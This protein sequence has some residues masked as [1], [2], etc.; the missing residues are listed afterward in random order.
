MEGKIIDFSGLS[1]LLTFGRPNERAHEECA[2][3]LLCC[4]FHVLDTHQVSVRILVFRRRLRLGTGGRLVGCERK[5]RLQRSNCCNRV[6]ALFCDCYKQYAA[7]GS[8]AR[9]FFLSLYF[10]VVFGQC[11][12]V[13][14]ESRS[15]APRVGSIF[16]GSFA[17]GNCLCF[18]PGYVDECLFRMYIHTMQSLFLP[19]SS[20]HAA[21][22]HS[23]TSSCMRATFYVE[24]TVLPSPTPATK[25]SDKS[26]GPFSVLPRRP[27]P[28]VIPAC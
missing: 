23:G 8:L 25:G 17:R 12:L 20:F 1:R 27:S 24:Q 10:V 6:R 22:L 3:L 14:T 26:F 19:D 13:L 7:W 15:A 2:L 21:A 11:L 28:V 16:P 4:L 18:C 9:V 5:K